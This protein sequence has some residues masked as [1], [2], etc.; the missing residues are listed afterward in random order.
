MRIAR[1]TRVIDAHEAALV[2][3]CSDPSTDG[4][5]ACII[6]YIKGGYNYEQANEVSNDG[7][8]S[9]DELECLVDSDAA[10]DCLYNLL[11]VFFSRKIHWKTKLKDNSSIK[12][13][14][15]KIN[16]PFPSSEND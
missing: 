6:D 12:N 4:S 10:I 2:A 8:P 1:N 3:I 15:R 11:I 5:E 9:E 14:T 16:K 13:I 7:A